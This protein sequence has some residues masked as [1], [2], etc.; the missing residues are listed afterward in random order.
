MAHSRSWYFQRVKKLSCAGVSACGNAVSMRPH[1]NIR[2]RIVVYTCSCICMVLKYATA[3]DISEVDLGRF[4][5]RRIA[6]RACFV[7]SPAESIKH[8]KRETA[9]TKQWVNRYVWYV[10]RVRW[11][12]RELAEWPDLLC[13]PACRASNKTQAVPTIVRTNSELTN[14]EYDDGGGAADDHGDGDD[15]DI[16]KTRKQ[17]SR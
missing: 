10:Q 13:Q 11:H 7:S 9:A 5:R 14:D 1:Q 2:V 4:P 8:D 3:S 16:M 17:V 6:V 15:D 12:K